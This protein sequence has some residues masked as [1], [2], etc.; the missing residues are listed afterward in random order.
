MNSG[1][2][3]SGIALMA[4]RIAIGRLVEVVAVPMLVSG[5][6]STSVAETIVLPLGWS[7]VTWRKDTGCRI[8]GIH[9]RIDT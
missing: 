3:N 5:W 6:S 4:R 9:R 1:S 2:S 7:R 8:Q